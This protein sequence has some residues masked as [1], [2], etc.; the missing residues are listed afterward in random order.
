M[1]SIASKIGF[2]FGIASARSLQSIIPDHLLP[3]DDTPDNNIPDDIIPD[4]L[5]LD[6]LSDL[7]HLLDLAQQKIQSL[8][9]KDEEKTNSIKTLESQQ[10]VTDYYWSNQEEITLPAGESVV[11]KEW[12]VPAGQTVDIQAKLNTSPNEINRVAWLWISQDGNWVAR[13]ADESYNTGDNA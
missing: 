11:I 1:V 13:S 6:M 4:D 5:I 2:M 3:D 10:I 7:T 8:E 12:I 9:K